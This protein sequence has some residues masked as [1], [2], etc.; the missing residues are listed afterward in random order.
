M[1]AG[2]IVVYALIAAAVAATAVT[3]IKAATGSGADNVNDAFGD[4]L[5]TFF[6]SFAANSVG[7]A[8]GAAG[9]GASAGTDTGMYA[10]VSDTA[11]EASLATELAKDGIGTG[12]SAAAQGAGATAEA[13]AETGSA[14]AAEG[15]SDIGAMVP[16]D[17]SQ[18]GTDIQNAGLT[19]QANTVMSE[20]PSSIMEQLSNFSTD[21]FK[22]DLFK[23]MTNSDDRYNSLFE[24]SDSTE[25]GIEGINTF[26][27]QQQSNRMD[28]R[29]KALQNQFTNMRASQYS[30]FGNPFSGQGFE[31]AKLAEQEQAF[32]DELFAE[33]ED[34]YGS[35]AG[36]FMGGGTGFA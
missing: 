9:E 6:I 28:Q 20:Q 21:G 17:I 12:T 31:F 32:A 22:K 25:A 36:S 8:A 18:F 24:Y 29:N 3:G 5:K 19:S 33:Q 7:G 23:W 30:G 16:E 10:G 14:M 35:G 4:W 26:D 34:Y 27:P 2:V 13:L 1:T 11:L 15:I